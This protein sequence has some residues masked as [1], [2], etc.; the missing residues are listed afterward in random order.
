MG[1]TAAKEPLVLCAGRRSIGLTRSIWV[2]VSNGNGMSVSREDPASRIVGARSLVTEDTGAAA[3]RAPS[4]INPG[5]H[6]HSRRVGFPLPAHGVR[7]L[8]FL[9]SITYLPV[10]G[11]WVSQRWACAPRHDP[12]RGR[13]RVAS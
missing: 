6:V 12:S 10:F 3:R 13:A 1:D 2:L 4:V 5:F 7:G 8:F 11:W 9:V